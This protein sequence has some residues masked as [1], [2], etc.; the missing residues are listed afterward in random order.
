MLASVIIS[1]DNIHYKNIALID[2]I[3]REMGG[4]DKL[5]FL[6]GGTQVTPELAREA[7]ADEGF[8]RGSKGAHVATALVKQ[9]RPPVTETL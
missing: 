5:V 9:G 8:G 1:H 7:G 4:E 6:S 2:R 3:A